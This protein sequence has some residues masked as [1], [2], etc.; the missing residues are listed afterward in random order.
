MEEPLNGRTLLPIVRQ[1]KERMLCFLNS[2]NV[3]G[4]KTGKA[5]SLEV[6]YDEYFRISI[7]KH[8]IT[9]S[10]RYICIQRDVIYI[11]MLYTYICISSL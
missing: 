10:L 7:I 5:I 1:K 2:Y 8:I 11:Y 4:R 9:K 3:N 6:I